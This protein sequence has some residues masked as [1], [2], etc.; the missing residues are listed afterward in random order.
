MPR[1]PTKRSKRQKPNAAPIENWTPAAAG[2]DP[3]PDHA[4]LADLPKTPDELHAWMIAHLDVHLSRRPAV[5]GHAAPFD[6]IVH[7]FFEGRGSWTPGPPAPDTAP[8]DCIVWANRGGGKTFL[9]AI[10]T[11]LDLVF[12]PGIQIRI[13]G[14]SLDQAARMH[15]H[16]R[17]LFARDNLA[18]L[19]NG[20]ITERR[21]RLTNGSSVELLAQSQTSVR[22]TRVQKLRCDEVELFDPMVWEAAQ[23]TTRAA[24]C[25]PF[26]VRGS[27]DC[28]S[29]MHVPHGIM[30][31]LVESAGR[32]RKRLFK[33]GLID[34][35]GFCDDH[36]RCRPPET[37]ARP[38]PEP[39]TISL[40]VLSKPESDCPLLPECDGQAKKRA[41][42][43]GHISIEDALAQK[44][45]VGMEVWESEMLCLRPRR[46]DTVLPEFE[47]AVHVVREL[48]WEPGVPDR[49][50]GGMDFGFR[51]SVILWAGVDATGLLC[52]ADER[53]AENVILD[54]HIRAIRAGLGR[55]WPALSWI[56]VDPA[57]GSRSDQTG[58][59]S[60]QVLRDAGLNVRARPMGLLRS[61]SMV[62]ARLRPADGPPRL[63]I[64]ERCR[65]LIESLEKYHY[66]ADRPECLIP[67]KDGH[68]HAVDAL[69][70]L[71][72]NLD[73]PFTV[74]KGQYPA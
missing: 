73:R 25:G 57:G 65:R 74:A 33:W 62:R 12:K 2:V 51:A 15:T 69:R 47:P 67:V 3:E 53:C 26:H 10:A 4:H 43:A 46:S 48:P 61:L 56:G 11:T 50:V 34:V 27:I 64:H 66:P 16:L 13:L 70:Y 40:P 63:L 37:D 7:S 31:R 44:E 58:E 17:T 1:N 68:D 42:D 18:P 6:Y 72:V 29:T 60:A 19:V 28:L 30:A 9:G 59:G 14:G 52:I 23:L 41:D 35:L 38:G 8:A 5:E 55:P 21:I 54:E 32:G 49:W 71:I 36:H 39:G 22:G 45:R 20:R 24:V